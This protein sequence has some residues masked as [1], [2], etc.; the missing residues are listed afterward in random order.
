MRFNPYITDTDRD[1]SDRRKEGRNT[2]RDTESILSV[3][4]QALK[5]AG[6]FKTDFGKHRIEWFWGTSGNNCQVDNFL[7]YIHRNDK[8]DLFYNTHIRQL[9]AD[10]FRQDT[11]YRQVRQYYS[12]KKP[13]YTF[14]SACTSSMS[15]IYPAYQMIRHGMADM[16]IVTCLQKIILTDILFLYGLNILSSKKSLPFC[17]ETD[18]V[19]PGFGIASLIIESHDHAEVRGAKAHYEIAG[20]NTTRSSLSKAG[21]FHIDFRAISESIR[22]TLED[23]GMIPNK[24]DYICPHGNGIKIS[25]QS[26]MMAI[27]S[28]FQHDNVP[29]SNYKYQLS[30]L[31]AASGLFDL[32][33][34]K[35][36]FSM[37]SIMPS[38]SPKPLNQDYGLNFIH[39][40]DAL[41]VNI[42]HILK[43]SLGIDG[44]IFTCLLRKV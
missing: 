21:N 37:Q 28:I 17:K 15:A 43:I 10:N 35:Y 9:H 42:E 19:S 40:Q 23:T 16:V 34:I 32:I 33:I 8:D 41:S 7:F 11:A 26:E 1:G 20:I 30:Y 4:D 29:I 24:I 36:I 13:M 5:E 2:E 22:N 31:M 44:S 14:F 25:D 18:G 3:T 6:L 27:K 12:F 39:E 38:V